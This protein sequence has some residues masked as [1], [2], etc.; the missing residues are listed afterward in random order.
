MNDMIHFGV[1]DNNL[2][3]KKTSH[4]TVTYRAPAEKCFT[5]NRRYSNNKSENPLMFHDKSFLNL[6]LDVKQ[7]RY[8]FSSMTAGVR[9]LL[10][11]PDE[12]IHA[13]S[14]STILS[15]GHLYEIQISEKRYNYLPRPYNSYRNQDCVEIGK[16]NSFSEVNSPYSHS[17]CIIKCLTDR[18]KSLCGCITESL[19]H[20]NASDF[21]TVAERQYCSLKI[22]RSFF[23][24][25][26]G[27]LCSCKRPCSEVKYDYELSSVLFPAAS[28]MNTLTRAN[29]SRNMTHA[30]NNLMYLKIS[31]KDT[32]VTTNSHVQQLDFGDIIGQLGGYMGFCLGASLL[33]LMELVEVV[34]LSLK[35]LVMHQHFK[36]NRQNVVPSSPGLK[37][38]TVSA[39]I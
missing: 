5:F 38:K 36:F 27:D 8:A 7:D 2:L 35:A 23:H 39:G 6:F 14:P 30:R 37:I 29:L 10:H 13:H 28:Y 33:T 34:L 21:C 4:F 25:T 12:P 11:H 18:T 15:P 24:Y 22:W 31:L 20:D 1:V 17:G 19:F 26:S 32:M 16:T 3:W 9:L